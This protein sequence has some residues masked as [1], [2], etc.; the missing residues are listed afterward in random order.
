METKDV[1][2]E[3]NVTMTQLPFL[4]ICLFS[5]QNSFKFPTNG[6]RQAT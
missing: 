1:V 6:G 4:K 5:K 2:H 3:T